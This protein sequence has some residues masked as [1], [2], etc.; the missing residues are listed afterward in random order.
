M[1]KERITILD[2]NFANLKAALL[3]IGF[4]K[5]IIKNGSNKTKNVSKLKLQKYNE[6]NILSPK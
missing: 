2:Q 4:N 5:T 1:N 6:K 3:K